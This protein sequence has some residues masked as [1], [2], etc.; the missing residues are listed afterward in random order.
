MH[1]IKDAGKNLKHAGFKIAETMDQ[2]SD[3]LKNVQRGKGLAGTVLSDSTMST[4]LKTAVANIEQVSKQS[5][6]LTSNLNEIFKQVKYGKGSAGALVADTAVERKLRLT[7]FNVEQG[8][9]RFN[10][11]MEAMK[12]N[13]LFR[14]YFKKQEKEKVKQK[15]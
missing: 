14:G 5:V 10:E 3:L 15:K 4:K 11:N 13:F 6:Q 8:T 2:A 12:H 9:Q 7:I 1:D